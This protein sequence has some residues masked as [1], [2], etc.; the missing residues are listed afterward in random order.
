MRILITGAFGNVGKALIHEAWKRNHKVVVFELDNKR[1]RKT[2]EKYRKKIDKVLFGDIRN[3]KSVLSAVE[4]CDLVIHM[5]AII[6]PLTK[7]NRE[8]CMDVNYSGTK[9]LLSGSMYS[10]I[11]MPCIPI[12]IATFL[13][14]WTRLNFRQVSA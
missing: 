14:R 2:A 11:H 5:A 12:R 3:L 6:P 4:G 8:L 7:R 9:N 1:N 10:L 13:V